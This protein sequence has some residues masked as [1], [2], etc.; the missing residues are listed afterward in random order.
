MVLSSSCASKKDAGNYPKAL[1]PIINQFSSAPP[2]KDAHVDEFEFQGKLVYALVP[3]TC[4]ADM[5]TDIFAADG[6]K[7]GMLGGFSGKTSI[8]GEDFDKAIFKRTLWKN[9]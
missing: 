5:G 2:C 3:G 8:N 6:T 7:L 1:Q 9:G 4:G